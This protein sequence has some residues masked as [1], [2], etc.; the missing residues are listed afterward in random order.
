MRDLAGWL[1]SCAETATAGV[2]NATANPM[3]FAEHL[4]VARAVAGH[5]GPLANAPARWLTAHGVA[6]WSGPTSLPLWLA[7][8]DWYGMNARDTSRARATG[9]RPRPLATTLT[10]TLDWELSR[11]APGPHGAELTDEEERALLAALDA[12]PT[13]Q[14]AATEAR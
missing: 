7:D 11:P 12:D 5:D 4:G 14:R 8:T 1:V 13:G 9:L 2:F 6:N 10:D 3:P